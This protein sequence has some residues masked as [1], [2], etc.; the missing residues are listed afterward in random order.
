[1]SSGIR[2]GTATPGQARQQRLR[3][4]GSERKLCLGLDIG[5]TSSDVVVLEPSGEIILCS[6]RRTM[7]RPIETTLQQLRD[8]KNIIAFVMYN[9]NTNYI[10]GGIVFK[11]QFSRYSPIKQ[12]LWTNNL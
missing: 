7:G 1:M 9:I 10:I 3:P 5:S 6:Y 2:P 4:L 11:R 12:A 8:I